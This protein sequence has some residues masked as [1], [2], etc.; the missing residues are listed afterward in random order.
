[1]PEAAHK[2]PID[3][4][5]TPNPFSLSPITKTRE[6]GTVVNEWTLEEVV[7]GVAYILGAAILCR[8]RFILKLKSGKTSNSSALQTHVW[9]EPSDTWEPEKNLRSAQE[10]VDEYWASR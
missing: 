2:S 10:K 6:L 1:M 7:L 9:T 8:A 5:S 3:S 4:T